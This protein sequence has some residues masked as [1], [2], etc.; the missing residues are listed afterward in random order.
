MFR[1]QVVESGYTFEIE[2]RHILE[3]SQ[4]VVHEQGQAKPYFENHVA[5]FVSYVRL[6]EDS[7]RR[8][9][10]IDEQHTKR[11]SVCDLK[12]DPRIINWKNDNRPVVIINH[13]GTLRL[14]A[15]FFFYCLF[16]LFICLCFI[17]Y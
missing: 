15:F 9:M 5:K 11:A 8:I 13:T 10:E 1:M 14:I 7:H 4:M 3:T 16:V 2:V 17:V 6:T 12:Y